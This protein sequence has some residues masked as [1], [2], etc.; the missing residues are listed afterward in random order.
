MDSTDDDIFVI[1]SRGGMVHLLFVGGG[2]NVQNLDALF[3]MWSA[4]KWNK[5]GLWERGCVCLYNM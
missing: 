4:R 2:V 3:I 1:Y 5:E